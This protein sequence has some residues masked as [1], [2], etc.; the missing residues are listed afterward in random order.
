MP[1]AMACRPGCRRLLEATWDLRR[2]RKTPIRS[3]S[4]RFCTATACRIMSGRRGLA[5][6][7]R[8]RWRGWGPGRSSSLAPRAGDP[9]SSTHASSLDGSF[10]IDNASF[11]EQVAGAVPTAFLDATLR[12]IFM[13]VGE[14]RLSLYLGADFS[15]PGKPFCFVPCRPAGDRPLGFQRP[16]IQPLGALSDYVN[17]KS[18]RR[19]GRIPCNAAE[20][21]AAWHEVKRQ[22]LDQAGLRLGIRL[23]LL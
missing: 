3:C 15:D 10:E 16:R 4:A 1:P 5:G 17:P 9:S 7:D 14:R 11:E 18:S 2:T 12:P 23:D 21:E 8:P 19:F 13:G 6:I 20:S 22:V